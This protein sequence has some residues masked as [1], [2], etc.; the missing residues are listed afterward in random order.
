MDILSVPAS[1]RRRSIILTSVSSRSI[2]AAIQKSQIANCDTDAL[3]EVP[4]SPLYHL[5]QKALN[6]LTCITRGTVARNSMN[7]AADAKR[8]PARRRE[9]VRDAQRDVQR[10][11][12]HTDD[13]S[14]NASLRVG[15]YLREIRFLYFS[16]YT[17]GIIFSLW[18]LFGDFDVNSNSYNILRDYFISQDL[19]LRPERYFIIDR[20]KKSSSSSSIIFL[21]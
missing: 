20:V 4:C 17:S 16:I 11:H 7:F 8:F 3:M 10:L 12:K 6:L 9:L 5:L 2:L 18:I 19:V 1:P 15:A 13:E 14:L 21:I